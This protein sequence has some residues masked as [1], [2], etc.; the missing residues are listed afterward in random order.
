M[1]TVFLQINTQTKNLKSSL[2]LTFL[3]HW[4]SI[5]QPNLSRS[6]LNY[7]QRLSTSHHLH[8]CHVGP[9]PYHSHCEMRQSVP[10]LLPFAPPPSNLSTAARAIQLKSKSTRLSSTHNPPR[11]PTSLRGKAQIPSM[12]PPLGSC[13]SCLSDPISHRAAPCPLSPSHTGLCS[14][15]DRPGTLSPPQL[16]IS[17]SLGPK[18]SRGSHLASLLTQMLPLLEK[19]PL[20]LS[21]KLQPLVQGP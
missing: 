21:V 13:P 11:A 2:I 15:S 10:L 5:H 16:R 20:P 4:I 8:R 9:C 7:A 6:S 3:A 19:L 18:Y 12:T 1:V 17:Y 14:S